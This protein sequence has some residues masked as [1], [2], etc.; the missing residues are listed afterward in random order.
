[1]HRI[2]RSLPTRRSSDL[3]IKSV[4]AVLPFGETLPLKFLPSEGVWE[5]RFLAPSWLPDGTYRCRLLMTDQES[6][7]YQEEKS[8]VIDSHPPKLTARVQSQTVKAGD[9]LLIRVVADGDTARL[10]AKMYGA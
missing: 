2:D 1:P 4:F 5:V 7:G 8:F 10:V 6:R 9:E 3:S